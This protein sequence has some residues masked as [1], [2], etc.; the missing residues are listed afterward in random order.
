MVRALH[1]AGIAVILSGHEHTYQRALMTW[2]DAVLIAIVTGGGGAP[3]H[4][5]P[6]PAESA[7]L[8]SEYQ[9]AGAV[10]KPENVLT[11]QVYNFTHLRLWFGG[12]ELYSYAVENDASLKLID[13]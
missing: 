5:M 6:T 8:F 11:D 1:D 9:V 10:V 3:L 4:Q 12:G 2:P 13:K 7:R